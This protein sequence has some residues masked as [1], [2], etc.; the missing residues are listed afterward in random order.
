MIFCKDSLKQLL[1]VIFS[2]FTLNIISQNTDNEGFIH[3][4]NGEN[5]DGWTGDKESYR[6]QDGMI[7]IEPQAGEGGGNLYTVGEY[8]DFILRFEF[9]LTPGANNGLGIHAP[10]TGNVAY[11]GKELQIIDNRGTKYGKLKEWQYHGSVYGIVPA[12]R[13]HQKP[14]GAWNQQE[15]QV[16]GTKIKVILNG[17]IIVDTDL[18]QAI[19]HGTIDGKDHPGLLRNNGHIGFLGHGDVVKFRNIRIREL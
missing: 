12:K 8:S 7:V 11:D 14:A 18:Q 19:D 17:A 9:L 6:A 16:Q 1:F 10:L 3:L 2:F 15:V 13:G 4:F 5:L